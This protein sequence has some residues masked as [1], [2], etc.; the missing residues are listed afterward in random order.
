MSQKVF[1]TSSGSVLQYTEPDLHV[2]VI[3]SETYLLPAHYIIRKGIG[4]G[5]YGTVCSGTNL[6]TNEQ[7]AIKKCTNVFPENLPLPTPRRSINVR[8]RAV[9]STEP[10]EEKKD[11]KDILVPLRLL[12]E[13]KILNHLDQ[14]PNI[15]HL[16]DIILPPSYEKFTDLYFVT[17]IMPADL[18]DFLQTGQKLQDSHIQYILYQMLM[19]LSYAHSADILHRDIKP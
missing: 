9:L 1:H 19:A 4:K 2:S 11:E 14:H 18:R 6:Q 10:E 3:Q 12:R 13:L 16:K 8:R 15:V 7:V 5:A 17:D